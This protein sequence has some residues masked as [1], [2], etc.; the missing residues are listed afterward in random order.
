MITEKTGILL[1]N[2]GTPA[3]PTKK[4]V[5]QYL[6]EFLDDARVIDLPWGIRKALLHGFILPFRPAKSAQAYSAIWDKEQGSPLLFHSQ[7]MALA[8]QASLGEDYQVELGMRYGQPS[9]SHAFEKLMDARCTHI[10]AIPLFPQY[11]SSANGSAM[12]KIL[13][14]AASKWNVPAITL[15]QNFYNHPDYIA[16]QAAVIAPFL[17][18]A[19]DGVL[20]SYHSL[21][22]RHIDKSQSD[23][24]A[25]CVN[26]QECPEITSANNRCYRAQ[27]YA[28]SHL[29]TKALNLVP[30]KI[31]VAF[32]SRLGRTVWIGPEIHRV[33]RTM[34]T[35]QMKNILVVCPSF[36]ADCVETLEE[37]GIRARAE[38]QKLGG[39]SFTLVPCMNQHPAWIQ[40]LKNLVL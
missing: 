26:H 8:L 34:R 40:A 28:T 17:T 33:M 38:W 36:V 22:Q 19:I 35:R 16:A 7:A 10:I 31:A 12:E 27:C 18:Q 5:R 39:E 29:L 2:L 21:P 14:L 9:I 6:K 1:V 24:A 4:A 37:I 30:E 25:V 13:T 15:R 20:F 32:Q 3:S 11:S 23:C